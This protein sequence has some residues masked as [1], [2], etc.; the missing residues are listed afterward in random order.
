MRLGLYHEPVHTDGRTYDTYGSFARYVEEFARHFDEVIVFAPTTDRPTY[1]SG[2]P[3]DRPNIRVAPLPY[4]ETHA[5]AY[6]RVFEIRRVFRRYAD[7]LDLINARGTAPLAYMLWWLTRK[8]DVP[9]LYHFAS[10]P[11]EA[12]ARNEKYRGWYGAFARTAYGLEFAIQRH[13]LRRNYGFASGRPLYERLRAHTENVGF[14]V[15]SCL[16]DADYHLREDCCRGPVIRVLYVGY[17]RHGKGLEDL[18]ASLA[19]LRQQGR[20]VVLDLVGSGERRADL[21]AQASAAGVR[22]HVNFAGYVKMGPELN[23]YY[24]N[25]DIFALPSLSEGSPRVII[26]ALGH[27]LPV[28]ATDVGNIAEQ[29]GQGQRGVLVP[30]NDPAGLA[31][32]L[33]RVI[34][35]A[36]FRQQCIRTGYAYAREHNLEGFVA[37]MAQKGRELVQ[38]RQRSPGP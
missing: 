26:E 22:E 25:A 7:S 5:Q 16:Q 32:G 6:R 18:V 19:I 10:D 1:Y 33:G 30:M 17:L 4:F 36:E 15:D 35:D 9:L 28:V 3:L 12:I 29:L 31:A 20:D 34:D 2:A 27:S 14:I 37:R 24:N 8:R 11:F 23:A 38:Q 21:E 13:I